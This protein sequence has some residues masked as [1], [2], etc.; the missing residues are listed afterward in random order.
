MLYDITVTLFNKTA[1]SA[2]NSKLCALLSFC[3][4]S[5][6]SKFCLNILIISIIL[7]ARVTFFVSICSF[8]CV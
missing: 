3:E 6:F 4:N 2:M 8:L 7:I 5:K 1:S